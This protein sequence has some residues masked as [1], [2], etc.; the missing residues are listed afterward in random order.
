M[1]RIEPLCRIYDREN[2]DTSR[3]LMICNSITSDNN[4]V[5]CWS[6]RLSKIW[7]TYVQ[8]IYSRKDGM[9]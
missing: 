6:Y 4:S 5:E 2:I 1:E 7:L 9:S 8:L 3:I